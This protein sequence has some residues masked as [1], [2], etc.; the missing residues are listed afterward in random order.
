[1]TDP[2]TQILIKALARIRQP[3]AWTQRAYARTSPEGLPVASND[4][5][6]TCWCGIGVCRSFDPQTYGGLGWP[7]LEAEDRLHAWARDNH[8]CHA[9][10]FNDARG[11]TQDDA[12]AMFEAVIAAGPLPNQV[13]E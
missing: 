7:A 5:D 13:A 9:V 12:V 2:A 6:A 10:A 1:M 8:N 11:R 4:R 3:G